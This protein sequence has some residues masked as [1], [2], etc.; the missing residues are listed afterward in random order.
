MTTIYLDTETYST[1]PIE[2]GHHRYWEGARVL[3]IAWGLAGQKPGYHIFHY[4]P[5]TAPLHEQADADQSN[6]SPPRDL[7]AYLSQ[8]SVIVSGW[9]IAFDWQ[10]LLWLHKNFGW[11]YVPFSRTTCSMVRA[12][13]GALPQSL[14]Q[15]APVISS[16][17][18]K[19]SMGASLMMRMCKP[20]S[21]PKEAW[22]GLVTRG[23]PKQARLKAMNKAKDAW[24]AA[25]PEPAAAHNEE[26]L[27]RLAAY[28]VGDVIC[29]AGIASS[30]Q[31]PPI[32]PSEEALRQLDHTINARGVLVDMDLARAMAEMLEP[33]KDAAE[34]ELNR[35]TGGKIE[36]ASQT[37]AIRNWLAGEGL[38]LPNLQS[39]TVEEAMLDDAFPSLPEHVRRVVQIRF[40]VA[41]SS[42]AKIDRALEYTCR[43]SRIRDM[44]RFHRAST[45]RWAGAGL[46]PQN[47]PRPVEFVG[48]KWVPVSKKACEMIVQFL[49]ARD[50]DSIRMFFGELPSAISNVLRALF[51]APPGKSLV[52]ADYAQIEARVLAEQAGQMDLVEAFR[53]GGKIY[54]KQAALSYSIPIEAVTKESVERQVGKIITLG[55]GYQMGWKALV[56]VMK[57][58]GIVI[59][60]DFAKHCID[61]YRAAN[62]Y[63]VQWWYD[64]ETAAIEAV[65]NPGRTT[66]ARAIRFHC[67]SGRWLRMRLPSGRKL[68]YQKARVEM[69]HE[70]HKLCVKF[71]GVDRFTQKWSHDQKAY[72]GFW[73]ENAVQGMARDIMCDGMLAAEAA[74][75]PIILTVHDE[76]M[77]EVDADKADV[78]AYERCLTD[79]VQPWAQGIPLKAEGWAATRYHK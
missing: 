77:S 28:C 21:A 2:A 50:A 40:D 17:L 19:D 55:S 79:H 57:K 22:A 67:E 11:P 52:G 62:P 16:S 20:A 25:H 48:G 14:G 46:Q 51:I 42:L 7:E 70:F 49:K 31:L 5:D 13:M 6:C 44:L 8:P 38:D 1:V 59:T 54:E 30:P 33:Y 23:M 72:G 27:A 47:Y 65:S 36:S 78:K 4:P 29:E 32:P 58:A 63:I 24:I 56:K 66:E 37:V 69:D 3:C 68:Y 75:Y 53:R 45:G 39:E 43:D 10:A 74:G 9:N 73:A 41:L 60:A 18:N 71:H 61:T 34:A 35:L 64:L 26:N 12:A 15:C 76:L